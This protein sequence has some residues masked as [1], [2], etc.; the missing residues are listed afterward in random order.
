[1]LLSAWRRLASICLEEVMESQPRLGSFCD[2]VWLSTAPERR[3]ASHW[4]EL[5]L[6]AERPVGPNAFVP[7]VLKRR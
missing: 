5:K 1:V 7:T 4:A 3:L 2:F 6:R